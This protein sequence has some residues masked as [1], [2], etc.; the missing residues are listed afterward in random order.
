M[1]TNVDVLVIGAGPAGAL[2]SS[3]LVQKGHSVKVVEKVHFPRF[4][5]GESLLPQCM[6]FLEQA[7]MLDAVLKGNFQF[8]NGAAFRRAERYT[9]FDFNEKTSVGPST[10]LQVQRAQFDKILID[11]A[12]E[13][14]VAVS[15]GEGTTAITF[16][17]EYVEI[18]TTTDQ[19]VENTYHA[20]F[21]LDAS[22]FGRALPKLL[23]LEQPSDFPTRQSVFTHIEDNITIDQFD[24]NKILITVDPAHPEVWFWLIP[25]S[26]GRSSLGVVASPEYLAQL[27]NSP[28]SILKNAVASV[29]SIR[30]LLVE[31]N[32]DT[33]VRQIVGYAANVKSL[34]GDRYA[35]LGNAGEFL[36]PV[37]SSGVTIA[38]KSATLAAS[39]LD[40]QLQ[41]EDV[42]WQNEFSKPL[43]QGVDTFRAYVEGWYNQT[44]QKVIFHHTQP[45][46]VKN[47]ICSVLAGYAWDLDNP[48]VND[49]KRK[50]SVLA[51]TIDHEDAH[52]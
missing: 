15:F 44:F 30:D 34:T 10:T 2:A 48:F 6:Q 42:N 16:K 37:F 28:E 41:G 4:S 39:I 50:L 8:K 20:K 5:I 35:L 27:G 9:D 33:D 51:A 52:V 40:R 19:C 49:A 45:P 26:N 12:I 25:F 24:R 43:N 31:A 3:L 17:D 32:F 13:K 11:C 46:T 22:G 38:L 36:D 47:K 21:I 1:I 7:N 14:G 18:N 23:D 29:P